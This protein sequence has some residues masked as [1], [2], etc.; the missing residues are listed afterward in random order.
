MQ[1]DDA[2]DRKAG[3][4]SSHLDDNTPGWL[5]RER[6]RRLDEWFDSDSIADDQLRYETEQGI[7]AVRQQ[8]QWDAEAAEVRTYADGIEAVPADPVATAL[9]RS[10]VAYE[11]A[12]KVIWTG[13]GWRKPTRYRPAPRQPLTADQLLG[14]FERVRK[15]RDGW[16]V[17]CPAHDDRTPSLSVRR[18]ERWWL[19]FCHAGCSTQA[20]CAAV[21]LQVAELALE[22]GDG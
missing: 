17:R 10:M 3:D 6:K 14:L 21:G 9:V 18:G 20:I 2:P 13:N 11:A 22:E 1:R 15:I 7:D 8:N 5:G 12:G 19:T 4:V 16:Q